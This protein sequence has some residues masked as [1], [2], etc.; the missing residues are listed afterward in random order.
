MSTNASQA[1]ARI[2]IDESLREADIQIRIGTL[3][4]AENVSFLLGASAP[5]ESGGLTIG[6]VPLQVERVLHDAGISGDVRLRIRRWR[7]ALTAT[8][9]RL[10]FVS[11]PRLDTKVRDIGGC[12][13][14]ATLS[15][16]RHCDLPTGT[17]R[18]GPLTYKA[19]F[20]SCRPVRGIYDV[21]IPSRSIATHSSSGLQMTWVLC[22]W[23]ALWVRGVV[24][25][26]PR[27]T[28]TASIFQQREQNDVFIAMTGC[29]TFLISMARFPGCLYIYQLNRYALIGNASP[30]HMLPSMPLQSSTATIQSL[31]T[32]TI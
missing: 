11:I 25:S 20:A 1:D 15:L 16:A 27:A 3:L 26:V 9:K 10:R 29:C 4:K 30:I 32:L 21:L 7:G 23:T 18:S 14:K 6:S 31:T 8:G 22:S 28:S 24:S 2:K 5:V 19:F 12:L 13:A 17:L